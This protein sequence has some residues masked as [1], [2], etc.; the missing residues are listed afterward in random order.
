M[1]ATSDMSW[2]GLG[3]WISLALSASINFGCRPYWVNEGIEGG[4][5]REFLGDDLA[6]LEGFGGLVL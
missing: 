5:V 6:D 1:R 4:P 3:V 2:M